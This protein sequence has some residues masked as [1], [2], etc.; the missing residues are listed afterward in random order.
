MKYKLSKETTT[1]TTPTTGRQIAIYI[2]YIC[3]SEPTV[4][5]CCAGSVSY[6]SNT[7]NIMSYAD[8][9]GYTAIHLAT[10]ARSYRSAIYLSTLGISRS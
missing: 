2:I 4:I 1:G 9:A 8:R 10:P 3:R 5:I 6:S 7:G